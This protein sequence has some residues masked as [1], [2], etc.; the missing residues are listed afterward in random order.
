MKPLHSV[1]LLGVVALAL[2]GCANRAQMK[3]DVTPQLP[4]VYQERHPIVIGDASKSLDVFLVPNSGIDH[5]QAQ[6]VAE[7]RRSG[8][9]AMVAALPQGA[10]AG[11]VQHTMNEIRRTAAKAGVPAGAIRVVPGHTHPTAASVRLSFAKLTAQ[12]SKCGDWPYDPAGATTTQSWTN[13]PFY[14][15]GCSYQSMLAAQTANPIDHVRSRA[16]QDGDMVRRI[17]SIEAVRKRE[18]PAVR[19]PNESAQINQTLR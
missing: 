17:G 16:D 3:A 13:K 14:N 7:F 1:L 19:W 18:S 11:A 9:G 10:P 12:S 5:R 4:D 6:D 15:L 2:G 8:K